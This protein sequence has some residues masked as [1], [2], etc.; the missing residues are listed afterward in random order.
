[1]PRGCRG[2]GTDPGSA[3]GGGPGAQA[4]GAA[5][6]PQAPAKAAKA[7]AQADAAPAPRMNELSEDE[8][9]RALV[10]L[11][12][13]RKNVFLLYPGMTAAGPLVDN[14]MLALQSFIFDCTMVNKGSICTP[15]PDRGH[16]SIYLSYDILKGKDPKDKPNYDSKSYHVHTTKMSRSLNFNFSGTLTRT[17]KAGAIPVAEAF[18]HMFFLEAGRFGSPATPDFRAGAKNIP[19]QIKIRDRW[20]EFES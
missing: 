8:K 20:P 16:D 6:P 12:D 14:F 10:S 4:E 17:P 18:N 7:E 13:V 3:Q 15:P 1:M 5:E 2:C 11:A 9:G 19:H